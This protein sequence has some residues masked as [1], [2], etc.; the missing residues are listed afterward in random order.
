MEEVEREH[1]HPGEPEARLMPCE[2]RTEPAYNA[3]AVVDPQV[4]IIV[5]A[6]A[7]N[8][9][10]D[11]QML[12]PMLE[13]TK[14][15]LGVLAEVNVADGG[16]SSTGQLGEAQAH[17]YEVL[18]APGAE[19]G[20]PDRGAY[21]SAHFEYDAERDEVIC[22]RGE[23]LK[24]ERRENKGAQRPAV[25]RYRCRSYPE[26]PVGALCSRSKK[27]RRIEWSPQHEALRQQQSKRRDPAKQA[28]RRRR[29]VIV[30]P[31][32]WILKQVEGFR[33]WRVRGLENV[34]TQWA[35]VCTAYNL[36]KLCKTWKQRLA[37]AS[38]TFRT[39][40]APAALA[41]GDALLLSRPS[42]RLGF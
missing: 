9:E 10:S 6:T 40:L 38:G 25:R 15:N 11:H 26:C 7:V 8:A 42:L 13:E 4:G 31:V 30:E 20:G 37:T 2:G 41:L 28:L 16:Y 18:V 39:R 33:R 19:T 22:P 23:R 21:D 3:Q 27:G 17:G 5:A 35:L 32:F 34:R 36:K 24:F 14:E 1:L 29:K 12:V